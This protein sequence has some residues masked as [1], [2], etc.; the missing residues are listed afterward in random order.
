MKHILSYTLSICILF[1]GSGCSIFNKTKTIK[2]ISSTTETETEE[3]TTTEV[4]EPSNTDEYIDKQLSGE[5]TIVSVAKKKVVA[6]EMPFLN[7]SFKDN[8][9]YGNAG[10]NVINCSFKTTKDKSMV[11]GDIIST[12]MACP[13]SK[14]E[15][16][17]MR[18][19]NE[20][21]EYSYSTSS[22]FI[23][24]NLLDHRGATVLSL[25]RH[26]LDILNGAWTVKEIEGEKIDDV[27]V[28]LVIDIQELRLH[29]N[30]G[31]NIINGTIDLDPKKNNAIQFQQ[32]AS[33]R[34]MC[35]NMKI[36]TALLVALE[37]VETF[38]KRSTNE[39]ILY[40]NKKK[41]VLIFKRLNLTK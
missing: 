39:I 30:S 26:N 17:I 6:E 25:K 18:A 40:D 1:A 36:E 31:C 7:F 33:T 38:K 15:S 3:P 37:K 16:S 35:K 28:N 29:G 11:L 13:N 19:L 20:V 27:N 8:R 5:W 12:L 41:A 4:S 22:G 21:S 34:K 9:I 23:F 32:L 2:T 10:C 14:L 24:L